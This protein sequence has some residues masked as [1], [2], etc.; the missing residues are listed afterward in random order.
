MMIMEQKLQIDR[1]KYGGKIMRLEDF[2]KT[3]T[4]SD[5]VCV[6]YIGV[7]GIIV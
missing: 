2:V 7:D 6:E 1:L 5:A 4:Y 3:D